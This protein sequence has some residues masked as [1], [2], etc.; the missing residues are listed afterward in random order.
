MSGSQRA[1]ARRTR[2]ADKL[3]PRKDAHPA[4]RLSLSIVALGFA[5][6]AMPVFAAPVSSVSP[7]DKGADAAVPVT[8]AY[9][10]DSKLLLGSS[11]GVADIERYNKASVVDPGRYQVDVYL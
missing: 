5:V 9:N 7:G 10:F 1:A 8:L 4:T 2:R 6:P 11:L 3:A